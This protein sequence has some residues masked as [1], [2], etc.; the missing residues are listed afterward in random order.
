VTLPPLRAI[1][2]GDDPDLIA[3]D[4]LLSTW[5]TAMRALGLAERTVRERPRVI[6]A[7]A[8]EV[9]VPAH[10]LAAEHVI[11]YLA[12]LP[13]AGTRSTYAATLS[14]WHDWL[15][16]VGARPDHPM[17]GL[18]RP[19]APRY[20]PRPVDTAHVDRLLATAI[21]TRTRTA[22]LLCMYAGMRVHEAAKVRGQDVDLTGNTLRIV[23]KGG[24][25]DVIPLHP[26]LRAEAASYPRRGWWFPSHT[27]PGKHV[28]GN[29]LSQTISHAMTRADVPGTAHSLR[30]WL[31]SELTD[32][33]VNARVGQTLMRHQSPAMMARYA[34]V[35]PHQ[36]MAALEALPAVVIPEDAA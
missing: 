14:A 3:A 36:Q 13:S 9:G 24:S 16:L 31:A 20:S 8:A 11:D 23:G 2:Q 5:P 17:V 29:S 30:H 26:I 15:V 28:H 6:R 7:A 33:N 34:L 19:K 1:T 21:R 35:R 25:D 18:K 12:G 10:R 4:R 22:I 32:A 27:R